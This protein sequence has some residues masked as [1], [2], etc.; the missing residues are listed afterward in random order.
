MADSPNPAPDAVSDEMVERALRASCEAT[1]ELCKRCSP[2][3]CRSSFDEL[4]RKEMRAALTAALS[5]PAP[6][7]EAQPKEDNPKAVFEAAINAAAMHGYSAVL[8]TKN[9]MLDA[10]TSPRAETGEGVDALVAKIE[11]LRMVAT[12]RWGAGYNQAINDCLEA[13]AKEGK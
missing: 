13:A 1:I 2:G 5:S 9:E 8:I 10:A 4:A 11:A 6:A 7:T 12:D 3:N